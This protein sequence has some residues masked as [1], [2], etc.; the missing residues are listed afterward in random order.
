MNDLRT[1]H[2]YWGGGIILFALAIRF[3]WLYLL[4]HQI[5]YD[6]VRYL[7]ISEHVSRGDYLLLPQLFTMPL[8]PLLIGLIAQLTGN[9]LWTGRIIS[10]LGNTLAVGLAMLLVRRLFPRQPVPAWLTGLGLAV[11]HIWCRLGTFI[12][13]D[14]LFYPLLLLLLLLFAMQLESLSLRRSL[15]LGLVWAFL[16]FA[17]DIGL[18]C[19][20]VVFLWLLGL[21]IWQTPTIRQKC[22]TAFRVSAALPVLAVCLGLWMTWYYQAFGIIS[23]GEGHRIY[24]NFSQNVEVT[25]DFRRY[26]DGGCGWSKLR[27][28]EFMEYTRFPKPGDSRYPPAPSFGMILNPNKILNNIWSNLGFGLREFQRVSLIGFFTIFVVIPLGLIGRRLVLDQSVI[29]VFLASCAILGLHLL[30]P[31]WDA[32]SF[33]WFFPWLYLGLAAAVVWLWH[34]VPQQPFFSRFKPVF[35]A[36]I[37]IVFLFTLLYP[38]YFKEVPQLWRLRHEPH[39]HQLAAD[40][41]LQHFGPGAVIGAF[42]LEVAYRAK[43]YWIGQP[44]GT[45]ADQMEWLYLGKADYLLIDDSVQ[46]VIGPN[47]FFEQPAS[48]KEL[49][50]ELELA[51]EYV[52]LANKTYGTKVRIF[53]FR[54]DP[55]KFN[56]FKNKY[57][58]AGTHP[59]DVDRISCFPQPMKQ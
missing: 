47:I 12:I 18:Y 33:A 46:T 57:P 17:R 3:L 10:I 1:R 22:A 28:Y 49:F 54:P 8:M 58:W 5:G 6:S 16:F 32:R 13:A 23:W 15:A 35:T 50:P 37:I 36:I 24:G 52:N 9:N 29:V 43:G 41:I 27:P 59:K 31:A 11:N 44:S 21:K 19:G 40:F 4:Q 7:W 25:S 34:R 2:L 26:Q 51:A 38:Q 45:P 48:I 30:G 56:N 42:G 14:N 20:L 39:G 53:R 55:E